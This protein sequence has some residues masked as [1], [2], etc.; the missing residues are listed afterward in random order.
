MLQREPLHVTLVRLVDVIPMPK[1]AAQRGR[2][3]PKR[4]T[5]RL[6]LKALV[7]MVIR[8]LYSAYSLL[9]FLEQDTELSVQLR[10]LLMEQGKCPSRRTWERRLQA[11]PDQLPA[12]IGC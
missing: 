5:E 7:I 2:G 1:G 3:C 8:R 12:L 11:L 9:K 4:Y 10:C 6:I